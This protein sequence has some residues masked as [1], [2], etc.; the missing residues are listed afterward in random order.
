MFQGSPLLPIHLSSVNDERVVLLT[1]HDSPAYAV[2]GNS[3][4][5]EVVYNGCGEKVGCDAIQTPI[6][7]R[8]SFVFVS[9][10]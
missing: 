1:E 4:W 2:A 6:I 7:Y 5:L 9:F 10:G 8:R 3:V